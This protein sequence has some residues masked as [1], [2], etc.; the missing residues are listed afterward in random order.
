LPRVV[1][2]GAILRFFIRFWV[3]QR[4]S[5]HRD[6][7]AGKTMLPHSRWRVRSRIAPL[8][9]RSAC[10]VSVHLL[11]EETGRS[12]DELKY[13]DGSNLAQVGMPI[14]TRNLLASCEIKAEAGNSARE[15][16]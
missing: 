3:C 4:L 5:P 15:Y 10:S 2:H 12:S 1:R 7:A 9:I 11:L 14:W 8:K 16:A 6:S 13:V